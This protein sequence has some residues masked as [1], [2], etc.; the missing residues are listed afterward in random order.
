MTTPVR[1]NDERVLP[2]LAKQAADILFAMERLNVSQR[3]ELINRARVMSAQNRSADG[4]TEPRRPRMTQNQEDGSRE[5]GYERRP[6]REGGYE[7]RPGGP[8]GKNK[9]KYQQQ[10]EKRQ[11][12]RTERDESPQPADEESLPT[13]MELKSSKGPKKEEDKPKLNLEI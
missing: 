7:R 9:A 13:V 3:R 5:G 8:Q 12:M 11:Q 1:P 6:P 4:S 2:L 10:K